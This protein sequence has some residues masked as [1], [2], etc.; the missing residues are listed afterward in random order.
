M[1]WPERPGRE[2]T[3]DVRSMVRISQFLGQRRD[4]RKDG[5]REE[6]INLNSIASKVIG[7]KAFRKVKICI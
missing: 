4:G 6:L 2:L 3:G 5:R 7:T 1:L